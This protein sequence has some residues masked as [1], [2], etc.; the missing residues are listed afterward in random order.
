MRS[1]CEC[2]SGRKHCA[3][4]LQDSLRHHPPIPEAKAL[5][6]IRRQTGRHPLA[7]IRQ[8]HLRHSHQVWIQI[9]REMALAD[10][11]G[12]EWLH[13][14]RTPPVPT[15]PQ[16]TPQE[17]Y[18]YQHH[19]DNIQKGGVRNK[20]GI[21]S[22]Y[23]ITHPYNGRFYM[24]PTVWDNKIVSPKEGV[25]RSMEAGI[26]NYPSYPTAKQADDRYMELHKLM[27]LDTDALEQQLHERNGQ[28]MGPGTGKTRRPR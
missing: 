10:P 12:T 14:M 3:R 22:Y 23:S 18:M 6:T 26:E 21:S 2:H 11:P 7:A 1:A 5:L 27:E 17:M 16:M 9:F 24:L 8:H 13:T 4:P 19:W 25:R 20:G 28:R 15:V